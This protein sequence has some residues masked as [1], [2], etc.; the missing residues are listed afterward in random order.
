MKTKWI[1]G[2][3]IIAIKLAFIFFLD[4]GLTSYLPMLMWFVAIIFFLMSVNKWQKLTAY[5]KENKPDLYRKYFKDGIDYIRMNN[6]TFN[7]PE[8]SDELDKHHQQLHLY[9]T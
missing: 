2:S 6:E 9:F 3:L 1:I 4:I 5:L 8:I 7:R